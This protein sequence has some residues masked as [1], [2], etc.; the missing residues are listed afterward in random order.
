MF[1]CRQF[2]P[3]FLLATI[4]TAFQ[5][6]RF[7]ISIVVRALRPPSGRSP[8]QSIVSPI[9]STDTVSLG[10]GLDG[11]THMSSFRVT[12]LESLQPLFRK[13]ATRLPSKLFAGQLPIGQRKK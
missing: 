7:K 8:I 13:L 10:D 11:E 12:N 4:F 1:W 9:H 6:L 3:D 5:S 2:W